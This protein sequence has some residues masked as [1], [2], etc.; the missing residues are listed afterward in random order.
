MRGGELLAAA[1]A[2]A[3][4]GLHVIPLL[5]CEKTPLLYDW[6]AEATTN[7]AKIRQ[8]WGN[9][10]N[11]NIGIHVGKSGLIVVDVDP[12]NGGDKAIQR[13]R[14]VHGGGWLSTI[15]T[16]TGGGGQHYFYAHKSG[17]KLPAKLAPGIDLKHD[18]GYIVAPPSIHP[19]GSSYTFEEGGFLNGELDFLPPPPDWFY[20]APSTAIVD[21]DDWTAGVNQT[22]IE[23]PENVERVQSAL[24]AISADCD[25]D[26]WRNVLF[27]VLSTE[28]ECA[29]EL[30]YDWSITAPER[31][32]EGGLRN[33]LDS[34]KA[35]KPN[36]IT[37]GTLFALA[38]AAGWTDSRKVRAAFESYGDI[39]NGRRLAD[40]YR[41]KLLYVHATDTWYGWTGQRWL[42]CDNGEAMAAAKAIAD[43][44]VSETVIAMRDNPTEGAKRNMTQALAVHRSIRRIE[45]MLQTAASE[46]GMSIANPGLLDSDPLKLGVR[47][48]VIDLRTGKLLEA[49][50]GMMIS[51]QAGANYDPFATCPQWEK[52]VLDAMSGDSAMAAFL[53]RVYG[54]ALTGLVREEKL[55]FFYGVGANGKSLIN[56]VMSAAMGEYA[57]TV[58]SALLARD[59]RG[60]GSD[61]EREKARL[62]GAR[63]ALV[64]ET[65]QADVWDDQRTKELV[66]NER[67]SA[68]QLYGESFDFM[69][70]HKLF[71]RGNHQPGAMDGS[72]GFW[73][74]IILIG[75]T[76]QFSEAERITDL[77]RQIIENELPGVLAWMVDGC[78][79][80]QKHGLQVPAKITAAVSE[81]RN[82]TDLMGEWIGGNCTLSAHAESTVGDLFESYV[83]FLQ[84]AN[85]KAPSRNA[86]GRQLVQRGFHKRDSSG[87]RYYSG[88]TVR[89]PFEGESL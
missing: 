59:P 7:A 57:V 78:M 4:E 68:R 69:P 19:S 51:R 18:T 67:V 76:R 21:R 8:W 87:K 77:D 54:Y 45:A 64:N 9:W 16:G 73:R 84:D 58:R 89:D 82:D 81:Y 55:F 11:A 83:D 1:L 28:W 5:P 29:P 42:A 49:Q 26:Q 34:A 2:Y 60:T 63:I 61:A 75:F 15:K 12:R 44:C 24:G 47:N 52:T 22:D 17:T 71:V 37:L 66:S 30:C 14:V 56:N 79:A 62:P 39:S 65:G 10:P 40:R 41:G 50:P 27:A 31:F 33:V 86:F 32:D 85:V 74:R 53:Q 48:G 3:A 43:E 25:R 88:L 72:D 20:S 13:L 35:D 80:W 46:P 38:K 70:T 23:S 36:G 6:P